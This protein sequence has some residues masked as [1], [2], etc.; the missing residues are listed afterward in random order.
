M[1]FSESLPDRASLL[2]SISEMIAAGESPA[3]FAISIDGFGILSGIE[4]DAGPRIMEELAGRLTRLIR[5]NDVLSVIGPGVFVLAG[6]G[7]EQVDGDVVLERIRGV[8]AMPVELDSEIVS[9]PVTIGIAH[10]DGSASASAEDLVARAE[11]DL[12]SKQHG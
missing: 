1:D 3:V 6:A 5:S 12:H 10:F 7:M 4:P 9:L 2:S 8:F 11:R